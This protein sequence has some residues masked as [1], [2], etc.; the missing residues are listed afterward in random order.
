[1]TNFGT[2]LQSLDELR[3]NSTQENEM[4]YFSPKSLVNLLTCHVDLQTLFKTVIQTMDCTILCG[5]RNEADQEKAVQQGN[6]KEHWPNSKHN[7]IPSMAADVMSYPLD[8]TNWQNNFY[9]GGYVMSL[10]DKLFKEGKMSHKVRWG[11]NWDMSDQIH[12][13]KFMDLSHFELIS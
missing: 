8:W 11:G 5:H 3:M 10:A 6:S 4:H 2:I 1:M 13:Q 7:S 9:F 12:Q